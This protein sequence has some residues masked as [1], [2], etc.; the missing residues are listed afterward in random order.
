MSGRR[1]TAPVRGTRPEED[2]PL[3]RAGAGYVS[4]DP[5]ELFDPIAKFIMVTM[6]KSCCERK[7]L[8]NPVCPRL[9]A[10]IVIRAYQTR[11]SGIAGRGGGARDE[12]E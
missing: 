5:P 11:E 4:A 1:A 8:S 9:V 12:R 7:L 6:R 10:Y 2:K 3:H